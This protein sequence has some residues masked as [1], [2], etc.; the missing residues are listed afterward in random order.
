MRAPISYV[1]CN[2]LKE[3]LVSAVFQA[4]VS[5]EKGSNGKLGLWT[6]VELNLGV[7][8]ACLPTMQPFLRTVIHCFAIVRTQVSKLYTTGQKSSWADSSLC[9]DTIPSRVTPAP[10]GFHRLDG[11][12]RLAKDGYPSS[13]SDAVYDGSGRS[14]VSNQAFYRQDSGGRD[15]DEVPLNAIHVKNDVSVSDA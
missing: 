1:S 15:N 9:A 14:R 12:G 10:T 2:L 8:A 6:T 5:T 13:L 7:I 3:P 11:S 4:D